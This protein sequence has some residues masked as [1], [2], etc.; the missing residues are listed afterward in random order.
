MKR[1]KFIHKTEFVFQKKIARAFVSFK[2]I[3]EGLGGK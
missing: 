2:A 3:P 1:L